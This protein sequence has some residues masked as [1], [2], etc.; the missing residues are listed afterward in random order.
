VA[1]ALRRLPSEVEREATEHPEYFA[2]I[3]HLIETAQQK[4]P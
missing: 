2:T 1:L 4:E 3:V